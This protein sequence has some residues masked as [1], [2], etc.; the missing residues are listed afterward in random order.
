MDENVTLINIIKEDEFYDLFVNIKSLENKSKC[1]F[2]KLFLEKIFS[3]GSSIIDLRENIDEIIEDEI[4]LFW[5][6]INNQRI[7]NELTDI[8][9]V[10]IILDFPEYLNVLLNKIK[11]KKS[12]KDEKLI[13]FMINYKILIWT[14]L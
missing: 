3:L 14:L 1:F 11:L 2:E 12:T 7:I 6:N 10:E 13:I 5:K 8:K 4:L 9:N